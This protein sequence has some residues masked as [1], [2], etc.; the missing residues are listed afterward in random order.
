MNITQH[1]NYVKVSDFG[2][3]NLELTL[4]CGQAFRWESL[5]DNSFF[6]IA[7]S[8]ETRVKKEGNSLLFFNT[9]IE[10]VKD[11]WVNYFDLNSDYEH[12]LERLCND[13]KI[14]L[15]HSMYGTIRLLNQG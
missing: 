4:D 10:D 13:K 1:K 5:P 11:F 8:K 9:P 3:I 15:A 7:S 12:I 6:G 2:Q 14:S